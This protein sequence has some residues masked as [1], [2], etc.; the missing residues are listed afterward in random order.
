MV[1]SGGSAC[2]RLNSR[3][4]GGATALIP[5][6]YN[7]RSLTVRWGSTTMA[8]LGVALVVMILFILFGFVD[9]LRRTIGGSAN[10]GNWVILSRG[11]AYEP[12]SV[13]T[14]PQLDLLR[15]KPQVATDSA[16]APLISPEVIAAFSVA[17]GDLKN[18]FVYL[19]GVKPIAYRVHHN[20]K[21]IEGHWPEPN[22]GQWVVGQKLAAKYPQLQMGRTFHFGRRNWT[23][24]GIFSD[25]GSARESEVWANSD[26][27]FADYHGPHAG[28]ANVLHVVLMPGES[29]A[30]IGELK[31]DPRLVLRVMSEADFYADQNQLANQIESYGIFVALVL[32]I[33]AALGGMNTMYSGLLRRRREIGLLR[34]LGFGRAGVL[35]SFITESAMLGLAGAVAGE[36]LGL[37][38]ATA[39]G[40]NSKLMSVGLF[41]FSFH[42]GPRAFVAGIIGGVLI[43]V[44]GGLFPAWRA[45]GVSINDC[46]R[47]A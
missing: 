26:D 12:Q 27:L 35:V 30:L 46:L 2:E 4:P 24:V 25:A 14:Q 32:S 20:M 31:N 36:V 11:A 13:I 45:A 41:V 5:L 42:L 3:L 9:G 23:I 34:A 7:A 15:N 47:E 44:I 37:V 40:L 17:P 10:A 1:K 29:D 39:I 6:S 8:A 22:S 19:R 18:Q 43:G 38:V 16:G 21:L 33:G 28:I